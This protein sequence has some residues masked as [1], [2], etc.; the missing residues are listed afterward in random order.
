MVTA[1]RNIILALLILSF[2]PINSVAETEINVTFEDNVVI[3]LDYSW[4]TDNAFWHYIKSNVEHGFENTNVKS[5]ISI[6]AYG[7]G[8][9]T[10]NKVNLNYSDLRDFLQSTPPQR[11]DVNDN[12]YQA[13]IE[14]KNILDNTT[15]SKQIILISNGYIDGK[16]SYKEELDDISLM[17]L[18]KDLK[19]NNIT[20]N[21]SQVLNDN[22]IQKENSIIRAYSDLSKEINTNIVVLNWSER[23]HFINREINRSKPL[24]GE[25]GS[26]TYELFNIDQNASVI[27][28]MWYRNE[29]VSFFDEKY[30]IVDFYQYLDGNNYYVIPIGRNGEIFDEQ[31]MSEIF[32]GKDAIEMLKSGDITES[33]YLISNPSKDLICGYYDS[34]TFTEQG[35]NL[36]GGTLSNV[37][38][39]KKPMRIAKNIGWISKTN[40][41]SL[42]VSGECEIL[43]YDDIPKKII[44]GGR[45]TYNLKNGYYYNGIVNDFEDYNYGLIKIIDERKNSL[46]WTVVYILNTPIYYQ[47]ES[48]IVSNNNQLSKLLNG[49]YRKKVDLVSNQIKQINDKKN[50][51]KNAIEKAEK[52]LKALEDQIPSLDDKEKQK[53]IQNRDDA[54]E[55]LRA[56]K[57]NQSIS[58]FNTSILN[59][60]KSRE[61]AREG[62][63]ESKNKPMSTI[64]I[65]MSITAFIIVA[66]L[67]KRKKKK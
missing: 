26:Y 3:L 2:L 41:L 65:A 58:K 8:N 12:I 30:E 51:S 59:A 63:G 25:I 47:A 1:L 34:D 39:L 52:Q 24:E 10:R 29:K 17:G 36:A 28:S 42:T 5:N 33:A 61:K 54:R 38:E 60:N 7:Y 18:V 40:Y 43:S 49:D 66:I 16:R 27:S 53:A 20:I 50:D 64:S 57:E 21:L 35:I 19:K 6:I 44:D 13:F 56:A 22:T 14:A 11:T 9:F 32:R 55:Y 62:I 48:S 67:I 46:I 37:K 4:G 31:K 15:G 23:L 45:Y